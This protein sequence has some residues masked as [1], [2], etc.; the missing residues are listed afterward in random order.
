MQEGFQG[1]DSKG[2]IS[3]PPGR[4]LQ[5]TG[6]A[7]RSGQRPAALPLP[8]QMNQNDRHDDAGNQGKADPPQIGE[9]DH[10]H[11]AVRGQGEKARN[12]DP[13]DVKRQHHAAMGLDPPGT[14]MTDTV[15]KTDKRQHRK[16]MDNRERSNRTG[17]VD[18][19]RAC[20][21]QRHGDNPDA[22]ED[23]VPD[24]TTAA[25]YRH[26]P[27]KHG[28]ERSSDMKLD[29][30]WGIQKRCK[31]Q[32]RG[33]SSVSPLCGG[34]P[35]CYARSRGRAV[36]PDQPA[37]RERRNRFVTDRALPFA[38]RELREHF[39]RPTVLAAL[40]GIAVVL[41][42]AGPFQS[43][44]SVPFLGRLGYWVAVVV[45][46]YGVG[47]FVGGLVHFLT[48]ERS[49]VLRGMLSVLAI[50]LAVS[51]LLILLNGGVG[52]WPDS[53][54][55][56]ASSF[57]VV[58]AVSAAMETVGAVAEA[59]EPP[60]PMQ[61]PAILGRLPLE[62]RGALVSMSAQ[63]HYVEVVTTK[64]R[65]LLLMRLGDAMR[66]TTGVPG[67]QVHRAHWVARDQIA[68]VEKRGDAAVIIVLD[69]TEIPV[70][71]S[72]IRVVQDA[73]LLPSRKPRRS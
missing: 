15:P 52:I 53:L 60:A 50:T 3:L 12:D 65:E 2:R 41:A 71:R 16:H 43:L 13:E 5:G 27:Q 28:N 23:P 44:L 33:P 63:D 24:V 59:E 54:G 32:D 42:V 61:P 18:P 7:P 51:P 37:F 55:E 11:P 56:V 68:S 22:T 58:L 70:S 64:G 14:G 62:K 40:A 21:G 46:T 72:G 31:V 34:F 48:R 39:R 38:L 35:A 17:L 30:R 47:F 26:R 9:Q 66:E 10:A 20:G 36:H 49:R 19:E 67:L 6:T 57:L 4:Y 29:H 45:I 8:H 25:Q 69:G 1:K 73:G